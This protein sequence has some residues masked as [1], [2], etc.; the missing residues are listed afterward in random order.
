[1][2]DKRVEK[3]ATFSTDPRELDDKTLADEVNLLAVDSYPV[4]LG[5]TAT[6]EEMTADS[7]TISGVKDPVYHSDEEDDE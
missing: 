7:L 3:T 4:L 1:M 2:S 5:N 6:I